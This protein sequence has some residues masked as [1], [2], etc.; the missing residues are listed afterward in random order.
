MSWTYDIWSQNDSYQESLPYITLSGYS[1]KPDMSHVKLMWNIVSGIWEGLP[2]I[3]LA[4]VV[5]PPDMTNVKFMWNTTPDN[6]YGLPYIPYLENVG[7]FVNCSNLVSV[8][9]PSSVKYIDYYSFYGT[10]LT[11]VTIASDCV[12]FS[13]SFPPGCVV[14]FYD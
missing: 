13:T 9:I 14:N 6:N 1:E 3:V 7:A 5:S 8:T 11:S 4:D 10:G 2:Y 12:Y